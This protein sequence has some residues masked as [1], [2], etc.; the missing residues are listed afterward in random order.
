MGG[1]GRKRRGQVGGVGL[2]AGAGAAAAALAA[3]PRAGWGQVPTCSGLAQEVAPA[4]TPG[5]AQRRIRTYEAEF[6][7]RGEFPGGGG[8]ASGPYSA[9]YPGGMTCEVTLRPELPAEGAWPLAECPPEACAWVVLLQISNLRLR[10]YSYTATSEP[11]WAADNFTIYNV[12]PTGERELLRQYSAR[13]EYPGRSASSEWLLAKD[14][15]FAIWDAA[16]L[17]GAGASPQMLLRFETAADN[18]RPTRPGDGWSVNFRLGLVARTSNALAYLA[19][20]REGDGIL[21]LPVPVAIG[22]EF[23]TQSTARC[24]N[25][26]SA[27]RAS[28]TASSTGPKWCAFSSSIE[29]L[30]PLS[31]TTGLDVPALAVA[32]NA[33]LVNLSGLE[34]VRRITGH[35]AV[36]LNGRSL[37]SLAGLEALMSVGGGLRIVA[38]EALQSLSSLGNLSSVG[39]AA[40]DNSAAERLSGV[41]IEGSRIVRSLNGTLSSLSGLDALRTVVGKFKIAY[42]GI[43]SLE[44]LGALEQV[45]GSFF[46]TRNPLLQTLAGA[47]N[48][49][50]VAASLLVLRNNQLQSS[51]GF[52]E[53]KDIGGDLVCSENALLEDLD[54]FGSLQ[55]VRGDIYIVSN[56]ILR[57]VSGLRALIECNSMSV[58]NNGL[59][60]VSGLNSLRRVIKLL[61]FQSNQELT[62]ISGLAALTSVGTFEV[63]GNRQ[64]REFSPE[65]AALLRVVGGDFLFSFSGFTD[66]PPFPSL[67]LI[68]GDMRIERNLELQSLTGM[69]NLRVVGSLT[70]DQNAPLNT[71]TGLNQLRA[72]DAPMDVLISAGPF[73][74]LS[75]LSSFFASL[76][77]A[78]VLAVLNTDMERLPYFSSLTKVAAL[79]CEFNHL[80][81]DFD[82]TFPALTQVDGDAEINKNNRLKSMRGLERLEEIRGRLVIQEDRSLASLDGLSG[83]RRLRGGL[84]IVRNN[85]L[86]DVSALNGLDFLN[87]SQ[88]L[89]TESGTSLPG[90]RVV[91]NRKLASAFPDWISPQTLGGAPAVQKAVN[92][93]D[94]AFYGRVPE[95]ICGVQGLLEVD[96]GGNPRMCGVLPAQCTRIIGNVG[97]SVGSAC[98]DVDPP[99]CGGTCVL[100]IANITSDPLRIPFSF[101][102]F[103]D[104]SGLPINYEWAVGSDSG[105]ECC[106]QNI[107]QFSVEG[108]DIVEDVEGVKKVQGAYDVKKSFLSF[109]NGF[110]YYISA[111]AFN[112]DLLRSEILTTEEGTLVDT[113]PPEVEMASCQLQ[114]G[115]FLSPEGG[116][117]EFEAKW[118][119]FVE[120]ESSI[121]SYKYELLSSPDGGNPKYTE[122]DSGEVRAPQRSVFFS[123]PPAPGRIYEIRV[124]AVNRASLPSSAVTCQVVIPGEG[125]TSMAL[126]LS[127]G[128][129][130]PFLCLLVAWYFFQ[131]WHQKRMARLR[132]MQRDATFLEE[133]VE[134]ALLPLS[135]KTSMLVL[136]TKKLSSIDRLV[137]VHTD[138]Q[139]SSK[140]SNVNRSAYGIIQQ[141]HDAIV[142][143]ALATHGGFEIA[144]EGDAFQVAFAVPHTALEFSFEVQEA[145]LKME[146]PTEVYEL[147]GEATSKIYGKNGLVWAGPR[148][149]MGMHLASRRKDEFTIR[150]NVVTHRLSFK[151][152][153]WEVAKEVGDIG[154]GGQIIMTP[155]C[156]DELYKDLSLCGFPVLSPIGTYALESLG[157]KPLRMFQAIP[158]SI[159]DIG[160]SP[161]AER[162][163]PDLRNVL[164]L[165]DDAAALGQGAPPDLCC[166]VC[167][168]ISVPQK[169]SI[170]TLSSLPLEIWRPFAKLQAALAE[171]FQGHTVASGDSIY[172]GGSEPGTWAL[173]GTDTRKVRRLLTGIHAFQDPSNAV[174]YAL[175]LQIILLREE[176]P[177]V[178][179]SK[180]GSSLQY[181]SRDEE[182]GLLYRGLRCGSLVHIISG[183]NYTP[184]VLRPPQFGPIARAISEFNFPEGKTDLQNR[185]EAAEAMDALL[186]L[187]AGGQIVVT[188]PVWSAVQASGFGQIHL[189]DLGWLRGVSDD[190][191]GG[192]WA[193]GTRLWEIL[194][195]GL[196]R[197]SVGISGFTPLEAVAPRGWAVR[198]SAKGAP[199]A[200]MPICPVFIYKGD[201]P[202]ANSRRCDPAV[203]EQSFV[204][205]LQNTLEVYGGYYVKAMGAWSYIVAF[206]DP[207]EALRWCVAVMS[208]FKNRGAPGAVRMGCSW[209]IPTYC[210]ASHSTGRIDYF[211]TVMNVSSRSASAANPGQVIFAG[212]QAV[213]VEAFSSEGLNLDA[214]V[215]EGPRKIVFPVGGAGEGWSKVDGSG[216]SFYRSD[217]DVQGDETRCSVITATVESTRE[218][219]VDGDVLIRSAMRKGEQ[220]DVESDL[221]FLFLGI[222]EL[223][224]IKLPSGAADPHFLMHIASNTDKDDEILGFPVPVAKALPEHQ[225]KSVAQLGNS[226]NLQRFL[227]RKSFKQM[228]VSWGRS[229]DFDPD[230][231]DTNRSIRFSDSFRSQY[232]LRNSGRIRESQPSLPRDGVPMFPPLNRI[233]S[234][235]EDPLSSPDTEVAFIS[236]RSDL[237]DPKDLS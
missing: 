148:V 230:A 150:E 188:K 93:V 136:D 137:F 204:D 191:A 24:V 126:I 207:M 142:R 100:D 107:D 228:S 68:G 194:P 42:T 75:G 43:R 55:Q 10:E 59:R 168:S 30:S 218:P 147:D 227:L 115:H 105:K 28:E 184:V 201:P 124:R 199:R 138:V 103:T 114:V 180:W 122:V 11:P 47:G 220:L 160:G 118:E 80:V 226:Q 211:G 65:T 135:R 232:S 159:R 214:V 174:R 151:G 181:E 213:C 51:R 90:V 108:L 14:E 154:A 217:E 172:A 20:A 134:T 209:G 139:N 190:G 187:V 29:N 133:L 19:A 208:W 119:G 141:R 60:E 155:A 225:Y 49:T 111:R 83:L 96:V 110:T 234:L 212:S 56:N 170:E 25:L 82:R 177:V 127:L 186:P 92:L 12:A 2:W 171:Q 73:R 4:G 31:G 166:L 129:G 94:N 224:N 192:T 97:T 210:T 128:L 88:I 27:S 144:T 219:L 5:G 163:F 81:E 1:A 167:N 18:P 77:E 158:S 74:D 198:D 104:P 61:K 41:Q 3:A 9:G 216:I 37:Q 195:K 183:A 169:T 146:W 222:F 86:E 121:S 196:E 35:L 23:P 200:D 231:E 62:R 70:F 185:A 66:F 71:V 235:G 57:D 157:G 140:L 45:D 153:G 84:D 206:E 237:E 132:Q 58:Y 89:M 15:Y 95:A 106:I 39:R 123:I 101:D 156:R 36:E 79:K 143:K 67:E 193:A 16:S 98:P 173:P 189:L 22:G 99:V 21:A 102:A 85:G 54:G 197:R 215:K 233:E 44:G 179:W 109:E 165:P 205:L 78:G 202:P 50:S 116:K 176:W 91:Q 223:K 112:T 8:V 203:L 13:A 178:L 76:T 69:N 164:R 149:R 125:G 162:V 7:A 48:L 120:P 63:Y 161:L 87:A 152:P 117:A 40:G 34:D 72:S 46:I 52:P 229:A 17:A 131:R 221:K 53:L 38:N 113:S 26:N 145:L 130:I 175:A 236:P 64:L 32:L 33:G 6:E 182:G